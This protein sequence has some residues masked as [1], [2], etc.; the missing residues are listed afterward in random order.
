MVEGAMAIARVMESESES[1]SKGKL[2]M[3][4]LDVIS[5]DCCSFAALALRD[6]SESLK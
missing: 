5:K 2:M 6:E 3:L 1:K 4:Y